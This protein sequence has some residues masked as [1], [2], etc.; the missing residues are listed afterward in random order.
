M[1]TGPLGRSVVGRTVVP[2]DRRKTV[3]RTDKRPPN[4]KET[5]SRTTDDTF[6]LVKVSV[7]TGERLD[8]RDV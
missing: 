7:I 1:N 2:T 4:S 3:G 6:S 8:T 5:P